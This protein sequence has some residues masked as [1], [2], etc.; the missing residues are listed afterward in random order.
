MMKMNA[1]ATQAQ[2]ALELLSQLPAYV[3]TR[4]AIT[5][6]MSVSTC[7]VSIRERR[8]QY[9]HVT[10]HRSQTTTYCEGTTSNM[11]DEDEGEEHTH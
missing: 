2:P 11:V 8:R 9:S 4:A 3:P 7:R 10:A 5:L 1:K 6:G